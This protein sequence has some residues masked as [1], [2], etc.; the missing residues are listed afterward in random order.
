M[1]RSGRVTRIE[2][3]TLMV[4]YAVTLPLLAGA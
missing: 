1:A 4:T 2:A 3:V